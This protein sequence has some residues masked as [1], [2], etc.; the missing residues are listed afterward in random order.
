MP[1]NKRKSPAQPPET[2]TDDE[3]RYRSVKTGG[4]VSEQYAKKHPDLVVKETG[5]P[6]EE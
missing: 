3:V 2:P 4:Y 1:L 6:A 5:E